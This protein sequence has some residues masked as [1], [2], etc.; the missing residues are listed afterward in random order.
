VPEAFRLPAF[1][2]DFFLAQIEA[3]LGA[4]DST[5]QRL[6][7]LREAVFLDLQSPEQAARSALAALTVGLTIG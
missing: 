4:G 5:L 2:P 1:L 3:Y 7:Y 6:R